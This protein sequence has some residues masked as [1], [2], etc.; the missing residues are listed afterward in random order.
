MV[1]EFGDRLSRKCPCGGR[2]DKLLALEELLEEHVEENGDSDTTCIVFVTRRITAVALDA[3]F[4]WR[5]Q[6]LREDNWRRAGTVRRISVPPKHYCDGDFVSKNGCSLPAASSAIAGNSDA[7]DARKSSLVDIQQEPAT[8]AS[9]MGQFDSADSDN[10]MVDGLRTAQLE[11]ST[12]ISIGGDDVVAVDGGKGG[13]RR[14]VSNFQFMDADDDQSEAV[15]EY[16]A[17]IRKSFDNSRTQQQL[18]KNKNANVDQIES[19]SLKNSSVVVDQ[20]EDA[21]GVT[22]EAEESRNDKGNSNRL[23][24][25]DPELRGM[26]PRR[27]KDTIRSKSLV[28]KSTSIFK[29]LN[30]SRRYRDEEVQ[31][32]LLHQKTNIQSVIGA[33]RRKEVSKYYLF[34]CLFFLIPSALKT[35][36]DTMNYPNR[37]SYR[38]LVG[39]RGC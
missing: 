23:F 26:A 9:S 20:F 10:D 14:T 17:V 11:E 1:A 3:F 21:T 8:T 4:R 31:R 36:N 2:S 33:L 19:S 28:R 30:K 22:N 15:G 5:L 18:G 37:C 27:I 35:Q 7:T 6:Q 13:V 39:G 16:L 29:G 12:T 34:S 24:M 32:I 38:H 25:C